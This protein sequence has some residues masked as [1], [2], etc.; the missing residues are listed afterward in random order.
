[1][2]SR[3]EA[4]KNLVNIVGDLVVRISIVK[5]CSSRNANGED[6]PLHINHEKKSKIDPMKQDLGPYIEKFNLPTS[7][8]IPER[9]Y[10]R[11][12]KG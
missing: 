5:K 11:R 1:M 3:K 8:L 2:Y 12:T 4:T 6:N 10:R 9:R 7:S